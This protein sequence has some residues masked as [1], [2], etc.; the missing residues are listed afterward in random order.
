[1]A[2]IIRVAEL[3]NIALVGIGAMSPG[4]T[5]V[6]FG[7]ISQQEMEILKKQGAVGDILGQF[8]NRNGEKMDVEYHDRLIA[9][10][11]EK[12]KDMDHVIGVAGGEHKEEAIRAALRG[13]LIHSLITDEVTALKLLEG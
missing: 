7:Y 10:S 6:S 11:L 4:A 13:R 2:R 1:V 8:Y 3:A 12:L 5:Y 9:V